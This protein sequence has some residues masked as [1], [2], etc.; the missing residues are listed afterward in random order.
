[1]IIRMQRKCNKK[2]YSLDKTD[3]CLPVNFASWR[4]ARVV[5]EWWRHAQEAKYFE[6]LSAIKLLTGSYYLCLYMKYYCIKLS[7]FVK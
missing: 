1:M 4:A 7:Q 5:A 6:Q 2:E 3:V